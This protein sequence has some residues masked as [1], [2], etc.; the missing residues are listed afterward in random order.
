MG[1][2]RTA[3]GPEEEQL[4]SRY[5]VQVGCHSF[6][7][8]HSSTAINFAELAK[9]NYVPTKYDQQIEVTVTINNEFSEEVDDNDND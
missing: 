5:T 6:G 1:Y 4:M 8:D 7:F 2:S 3:D 9:A